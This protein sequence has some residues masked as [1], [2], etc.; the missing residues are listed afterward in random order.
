[1]LVLNFAP[2]GLVLLKASYLR[3]TFARIDSTSMVDCM[4]LLESIQDLILNFK[5]GIQTKVQF[6]SLGGHGD[7]SCSIS[8][9]TTDVTVT[10]IW[11][12]KV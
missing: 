9:E 11:S 6:L 3:V 2:G 8:K 5:L 10:M 7:Q 12:N 4:P 1:M